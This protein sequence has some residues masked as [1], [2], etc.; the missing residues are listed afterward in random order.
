MKTDCVFLLADKQM[1]E[2]FDGFLGRDKFH[3]SLGTRLFTYLKKLMISW[4]GI[5]LHVI[6]QLSSLIINGKVL[7][8]RKLFGGV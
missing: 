3:L 4:R 2:T 7:L 8:R 1:K 6:I 5:V